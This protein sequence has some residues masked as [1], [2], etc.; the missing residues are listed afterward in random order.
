LAGRAGS[1]PGW[2]WYPDFPP[3]FERA[4]AV[5]R[6]SAGACPSG[7]SGGRQVLDFRAQIPS[8]ALYF[9]QSRQ[10]VLRGRME[11]AW[12]SSKRTARPSTGRVL[13]IAQPVRRSATPAGGCKRCRWTRRRWLPRRPARPRRHG[14]R[15]P[16]PARRPSRASCPSRRCDHRSA[17]R[18]A[19][20]L[21]RW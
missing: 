8:P 20:D 10:P 4:C 9:H 7:A 3:V 21:R 6:R 17:V 11:A 13:S 5:V 2:G 1:P 15:S 18:A 14:W 12:S 19:L 16:G